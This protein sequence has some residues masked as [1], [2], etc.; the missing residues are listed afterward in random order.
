MKRHCGRK[1]RQASELCQIRGQGCRRG[2]S[3]QELR[4][5]NYDVNE[6]GGGQVEPSPTRGEENHRR[7]GPWSKLRSKYPQESAQHNRGALHEHRKAATLTGLKIVD[8]ERKTVSFFTFNP[9]PGGGG[10]SVKE[11]GGKEGALTRC[12]ETPWKKK[13]SNWERHGGGL[14]SPFS[15]CSKVWAGYRQKAGGVGKKRLYG[16]KK[17]NR[18]AKKLIKMSPWGRHNVNHGERGRRKGGWG[19]SEC[20]GRQRLPGGLYVQGINLGPRSESRPLWIEGTIMTDVGWCRGKV[21]GLQSWGRRL[22]DPW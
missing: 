10:L 20:M 19:G 4:T 9:F 16:I 15:G 1:T 12:V 6:I 13:Q 7:W 17:N 3:T 11:L 2:I 18:K 14:T 21:D 8:R 22:R 5:R